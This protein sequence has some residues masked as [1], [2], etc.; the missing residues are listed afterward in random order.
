MVFDIGAKRRWLS[1]QQVTGRP[2][3][4]ESIYIYICVD[5]Y[6]RGWLYRDRE[7][8]GEE[9]RRGRRWDGMERS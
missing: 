2:G 1:Q 6:V 7:L 4:G 9:E 8:E 5:I 3:F